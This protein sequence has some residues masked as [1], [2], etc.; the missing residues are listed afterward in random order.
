MRKTAEHQSPRESSN[1]AQHVW[2]KMVQSNKE[3]GLSFWSQDSHPV[4]S[5][6]GVHIKMQLYSTGVDSS[7]VL[8]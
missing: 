7:T 4:S 3:E 6:F 1:D 2:G 5:R 8:L